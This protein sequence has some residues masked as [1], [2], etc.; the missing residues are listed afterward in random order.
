MLEDDAVFRLLALIIVFMFTCLGVILLVGGD[1]ATRIL[2]FLFAVLGS[3]WLV[4]DGLRR[5]GAI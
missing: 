2:G 5:R 1:G 4:V 3:A